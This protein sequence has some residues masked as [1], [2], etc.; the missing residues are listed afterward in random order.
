MALSTQQ[1]YDGNMKTVLRI[2]PLWMRQS[3]KFAFVGLL[4]TAV[5][6]GLYLL[7]TRL[8]LC[9]FDRRVLAKAISYSVGVLNSF[10][11][12]RNWTFRSHAGVRRTLVPFVLANLAG[13]G[14][15][16]AVTHMGLNVLNLPEALTLGLATGITLVWN[17]CAS[18]FLVFK[19]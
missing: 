19:N 9:F 13:V 5:D 10:I 14:V 8:S 1:D 6:L 17:F 16:S 7:L 4:N 15:N 11:W 2:L 12:N 3:I 18:K